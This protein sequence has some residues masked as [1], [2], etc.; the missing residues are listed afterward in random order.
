MPEPLVVYYDASC[1][2]CRTEIE[3]LSSIKP[4]ALE[5]HDCS[6]VEFDDR[7]FRFLLLASE[8]DW[9]RD[10]TAAQQSPSHRLECL[11]IRAEPIARR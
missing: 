8:H 7:E 1:P 2:L 10:E 4:G 6:H 9:D 5:L 3:L 11:L